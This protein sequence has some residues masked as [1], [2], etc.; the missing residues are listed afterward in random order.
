MK[1]QDSL[2][3]I[4]IVGFYVAFFIANVFYCK[5]VEVHGDSLFPLR[6]LL[7]V[8]PVFL[9]LHWEGKNPISYL[10]LNIFMSLS[11]FIS[12]TALTL[13]VL[14]AEYFTKGVLN[15]NQNL[16]TWIDFILLVGI[17]EEVVFRGFIQQK[18]EEIFQSF[19]VAAILSSVLFAIMHIP[20]AKLVG[21]TLKDYP[22]VA[23]CGLIFSIVLKKTNSLWAVSYVHSIHNLIAIVCK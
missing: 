17:V 18:L 5:A 21:F 11:F 7:W 14:L 20:Y 1:K 4:K 10:K 6:S 9:Y 3:L 23:F 22:Y 8:G 12:I 2:K 15:F 16:S 19:W 13:F